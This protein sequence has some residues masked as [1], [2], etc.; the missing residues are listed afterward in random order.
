VPALPFSVVVCTHNRIDLL[1]QCLTSLAC[2]TIPAELYEVIVVDNRSTDGT[3]MMVGAF[4]REHP[5]HRVLLIYEPELGLGWAR[6]AGWRQARGVYVAFIDDDA[7][8]DSR[9]LEHAWA[10]FKE[11]KPIPVAMGGP[12][13]PY[14][15]ESK[16][17]WFK[18]EYELRTWGE[19]PRVLDRRESLSGSNMIF[20]KAVLERFGGFDVRVGMRGKRI[21]VGEETALLSRIAESHVGGSLYYSPRL[22]VYHV[23]GASKM[24]ASYHVVRAFATGQAWYFLNGPRAFRERIR[25]I[26][27]TLGTIKEL[28]ATAMKQFLAFQDSRNWIIERIAPVALE[29]GRLVAGLGVCLPSW[30]KGTAADVDA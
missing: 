17:V 20:Q 4:Q 21:S 3:R 7:K 18:D 30:N 5:A 1:R 23:V 15:T 13:L 6:N 29:I 16:P 28:V 12:I 26:R 2:Q 8:A 19:H 9:W 25:F 14:Y 22:V 27:M 10:C 24:R 11:I